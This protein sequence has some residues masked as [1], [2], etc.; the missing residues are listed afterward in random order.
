[1]CVYK[2]YIHTAYT[3]YKHTHVYHCH[4]QYNKYI[5]YPP[6]LS[7]IPTSPPQVINNLIVTVD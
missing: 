7:Y 2:I 5:H 3:T 4:N 1:M 6:K